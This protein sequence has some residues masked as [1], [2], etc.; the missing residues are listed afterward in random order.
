MQLLIS[1][2][3]RIAEPSNLASDLNKKQRLLINADQLIGN[4]KL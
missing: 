2:I 1:G 4:S 3:L